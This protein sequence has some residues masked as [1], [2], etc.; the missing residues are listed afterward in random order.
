MSAY[1]LFSRSTVDRNSREGLFNLITSLP[2]TLKY[3]P[4]TIRMKLPSKNQRVALGLLPRLA[5]TVKT[6]IAVR[7]IYLDRQDHCTVS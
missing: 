2:P 5:Q 4:G 7:C 1:L 3:E 6:L